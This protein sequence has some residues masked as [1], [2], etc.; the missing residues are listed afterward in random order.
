MDPQPVF[1]ASDLH[2]LETVLPD[3]DVGGGTILAVVEKNNP[4]T[5]Y[6]YDCQEGEVAW[7]HSHSVGVHGF[8]GVELP[9]LEAGKEPLLDELL[10]A[11]LEF[12]DLSL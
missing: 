4:K 6:E 10:C 8:A 12:L 11:R 2:A 9:V 1:S 5:L 7:Q 3:D